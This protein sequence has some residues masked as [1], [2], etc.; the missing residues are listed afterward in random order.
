M[1]SRNRQNVQLNILP[2]TEERERDEGEKREGGGG[3]EGLDVK[4]DHRLEILF[5]D[6]L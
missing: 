1:F 6:I 2:H 5:I 4:G 3:G